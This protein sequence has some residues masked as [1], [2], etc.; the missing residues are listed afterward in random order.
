M[1]N[2]KEPWSTNLFLCLFFNRFF[3]RK[4]CK[5]GF[6]LKPKGLSDVRVASIA[7]KEYCFSVNFLSR[8][9]KSLKS[10]SDEWLDTICWSSCFFRIFII[11]LCVEFSLMFLGTGK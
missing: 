4:I 9:I 1:R 10:I 5:L 8:F 7:K 2:V 6:S 3:Y 11:T